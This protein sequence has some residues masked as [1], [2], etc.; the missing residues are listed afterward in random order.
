M[1]ILGKMKTF[2]SIEFQRDDIVRSDLVR[3]YICTK[4]D[5]GIQ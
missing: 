5:M 2:D 1:K 4:L 3:E